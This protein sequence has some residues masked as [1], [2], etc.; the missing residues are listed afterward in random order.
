[1]SASV[2]PATTDRSDFRRVMVSGTKLGALTA[3]AVVLFLVVAR[4]VPGAGGARRG[5]ETLI[6]LAAGVLASFLPGRW[7]TARHAEGIAG[8]AAIGLWGTIVFMAFDIVLLRPFRAYPWTWD[9]IGGGSSWGHLPIWW[10]LGTFLA[11][12]CGNVTATPAER[13]RS[14]WLSW[15]GWARRCSGS[16]P[17]GPGCPSCA[18]FR[19]SCRI[20]WRPGRRRSTRRLRQPTEL[21]WLPLALCIPAVLAAQGRDWEFHRGRWYNGNRSDSYE[22]RT[23]AHWGG[24]FTHGFGAQVVLHDSLGRRRAFY[25]LAYEL[26]AFRGRRALGP[27]ALT[28]VAL[29]LSTDTTTQELAAQ[30]S[31]GGGLAW[32][33]GSRFAPGV[34]SR[35]PVE[36]P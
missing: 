26:Q 19:T 8:A 34:E 20:T 18:G 5:M 29:G 27:Y 23:S 4:F 3:A 7:A 6:V 33:P 16:R 24:P 30:W 14:R 15:R 21:G 32:R 11:W 13:V 17:S 22:F 31:M 12:V 2:A 28:G 10:M 1:M 35:Y 25:G 36:D 9:A